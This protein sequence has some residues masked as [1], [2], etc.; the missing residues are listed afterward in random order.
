MSKIKDLLAIEEGI[1]DLMPVHVWTDEDTKRIAD[2]LVK[3]AV[4]WEGREKWFMDNA[5][6]SVDTNDFGAECF[7]FENFWELCDQAIE[8]MF[9]GYIEE[10]AL[11]VPNDVYDRICKCATEILVDKLA[12][13]ECDCVRDYEQDSKYVLDELRERNGQC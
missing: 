7:Y 5:E 6:F 4:E 13:F 11:D 12:D 2:I 10:Q 8:E 9:D 3:R 1:D